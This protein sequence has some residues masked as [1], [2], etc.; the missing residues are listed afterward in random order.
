MNLPVKI[1][2]HKPLIIMF[3]TEAVVIN[4][5]MSNSWSKSTKTMIRAWFTK[6]LQED[7]VPHAYDM[8]VPGGPQKFQFVTM[9]LIH[10]ICATCIL[11]HIYVLHY[12]LLPVSERSD[13]YYVFYLYTIKKLFMLEDKRSTIQWNEEIS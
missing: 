4:P 8:T 12:F 7:A 2:L 3:H 5:L 1:Y 9:H 6:Y 10:F 13:I 11:H